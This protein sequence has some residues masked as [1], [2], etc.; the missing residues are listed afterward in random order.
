MC[1][2]SINFL[3]VEKLMGNKK[4]DFL[5]IDFLYN[6]VYEGK[7]KEVLIIKNDSKEMNEFYLFLYEVFSVVINNMKLGSLFYVWYV[8]LEVVNFYIVLEEVGFLVK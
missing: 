5:I 1:G 4:V 8:L 3:E 2:D 6:V 7:G